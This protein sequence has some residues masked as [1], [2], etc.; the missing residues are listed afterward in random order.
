MFLGSIVVNRQF[1]QQSWLLEIA[2][3]RQLTHA[4]SLRAFQPFSEKMAIGPALPIPC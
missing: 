1:H 4:P 2:I 3:F